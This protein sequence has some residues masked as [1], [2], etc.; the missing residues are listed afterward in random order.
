MSEGRGKG[1]RETYR[2]RGFQET[3]RERVPGKHASEW[4]SGKLK[5]IMTGSLSRIVFWEAF[6]VCIVLEE[7]HVEHGGG[8]RRRCGE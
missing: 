5:G 1:S 3:Y 8:I 7:V 4:V 6:G 2:G